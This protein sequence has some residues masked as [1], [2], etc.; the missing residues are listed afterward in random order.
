[1]DPATLIALCRRRAGLSQRELAARARTSA[2]AVCQYERGER[3]PRV[4]TLRRLVAATGTALTLE[5]PPVLPMDLAAKGRDLAQV[6][7][8][9]DLLPKRYEPDLAYPPLHRLLA[10]P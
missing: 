7:D 3:V 4:D 10:R 6:L 5:A 1:M 8:L 2:A 9:A